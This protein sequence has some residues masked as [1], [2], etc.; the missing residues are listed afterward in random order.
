MINQTLF[1]G[2]SSS[3]GLVAVF[4]HLSWHLTGQSLTKLITP[5]Q[6]LQFHLVVVCDCC[7]TLLKFFKKSELVNFLI[8]LTLK[9]NT[10]NSPMDTI[11][12]NSSKPSIIKIFASICFVCCVMILFW[13]FWYFT[14]SPGIMLILF[15]FLYISI[16]I[17]DQN[18]SYHKESQLRKRRYV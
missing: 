7:I 12:E 9:I 1:G 18:H 2:P 17:V 16:V 11:Q 15:I 4:I 13:L 8:V 3:T 10:K 5:F 14:S 6:C